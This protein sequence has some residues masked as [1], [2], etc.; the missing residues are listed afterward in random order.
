[1]IGSGIGL[2]LGAAYLA[3]GMARAATDHARA[4]Y[5]LWAVDNV[6]VRRSCSAKS[7]GRGKAPEIVIRNWSEA[8]KEAA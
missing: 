7:E 3:G 2:G 6:Q 8:R 4:T 5:G 1:M